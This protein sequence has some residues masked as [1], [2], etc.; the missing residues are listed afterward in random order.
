MTDGDEYW[1]A[2]KLHL[3]DR[4][5]AAARGLRTGE[6]SPPVAISD[7]IHLLAMAKNT[8]PVAPPFP[9][10]RDKVLAAFRTAQATTLTGAN[11]RFLRKRADIQVAS[12]VE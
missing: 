11:G 1:F 2:A 7:G 5:F 10:V 6:V 9:E 3:G 8:P 12:D 4:L